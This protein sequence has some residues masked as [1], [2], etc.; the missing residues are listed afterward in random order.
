MDSM[1]TTDDKIDM[2]NKN[3]FS[4]V[5]IPNPIINSPNG[6]TN[7]IYDLS[8][9]H[10][11]NYDDRRNMSFIREISS[12]TDNDNI[13]NGNTSFML[14][15]STQQVN[16]E[17]RNITTS[18]I[19]HISTLMDHNNEKDVFFDCN[20]DLPTSMETSPPNINNMDNTMVSRQE[21]KYSISLLILRKQE[22]RNEEFS[23]RV[24]FDSKIKFT[25]AI[26]KELRK[27]NSH[28]L[29]I[30]RVNLDVKRDESGGL[31]VFHE[32]K[33]KLVNRYELYIT[34]PGYLKNK[35][36]NDNQKRILGD[37][38]STTLNFILD[39]NFPG[40]AGKT[41]M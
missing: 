33:W 6:Q 4:Y 21:I 28:F 10:D 29:L 36:Y 35:H 7:F 16:N 11:N 20:T 32:N 17:A 9:S 34:R 3:F 27:E 40:A 22:T 2:K 5:A 39:V 31:S 1:E 25:F 38:L 24:L 18:F 41:F 14:D 30:Y 26:D 13:I 19:S 37:P 8:S 12:P 23:I 15:L